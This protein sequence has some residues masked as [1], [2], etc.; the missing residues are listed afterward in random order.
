M[1]YFE[2]K[3][4]FKNDDPG[5]FV[6]FLSFIAV[7]SSWE[8]LFMFRKYPY[9]KYIDFYTSH[10]D[11]FLNCDAVLKELIE[12]R[13][14]NDK[15][16]KGPSETSAKTI[17]DEF[18]KR[19]ISYLEGTAQRWGIMLSSVL[20]FFVFLFFLGGLATH[21]YLLSILF[22]LVFVSC[23]SEFWVS[24]RCFLAITKRVKSY[25]KQLNWFPFNMDLIYKLMESAKETLSEIEIPEVAADDLDNEEI[26][27]L[28]ELFQEGQV[29]K[30]NGKYY[31]VGPVKAFL[32][33]REENKNIYDI[34]NKF[35]CKNIL[36]SDGTVI[37]P[38]TIYQAKSRNKE[39]EKEY[40]D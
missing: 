17:L 29:S 8:T 25:K 1:K 40:L 12:S 4:S 3:D 28:E 6:F 22:F 31:L 7:R 19:C 26:R 16:Y 24:L 34:H 11:L 38:D 21:H 20:G 13:L 33:W 30:E 37:K 10:K 36:Q 2:L 32:K 9:E 39:S 15:S 27:L 5:N 23:C 14:V 35:I 18:D